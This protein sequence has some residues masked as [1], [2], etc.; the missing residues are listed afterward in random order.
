VPGIRTRFDISIAVA[1][2]TVIAVPDFA[3]FGTAK[4]SASVT[5]DGPEARANNVLFYAKSYIKD[6]VISSTLSGS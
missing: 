2:S 5:R 4:T 3:V 1:S 6:F